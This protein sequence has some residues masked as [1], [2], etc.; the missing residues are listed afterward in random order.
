MIILSLF[1]LFKNMIMLVL[2]LLY[3]RVTPDVF[4]T[5]L[6]LIVAVSFAVGIPGGI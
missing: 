2:K 5:V 6:I 3:I 1:D 4:F